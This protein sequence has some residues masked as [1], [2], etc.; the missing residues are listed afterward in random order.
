M[1][2]NFSLGM[3]Q[4]QAQLIQKLTE[5]EVR[6]NQIAQKV[7]DEQQQKIKAAIKETISQINFMPQQVVIDIVSM[8]ILTKNMC[9]HPIF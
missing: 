2:L 3:I 1:D 8:I 5:L 6:I 9:L 4:N 7:E